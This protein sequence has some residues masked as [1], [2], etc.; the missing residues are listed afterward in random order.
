M[1]GIPASSTPAVCKKSLYIRSEHVWLEGPE[2]HLQYTIY[3]FSDNVHCWFRYSILMSAHIDS[4]SILLIAMS[5]LE[6]TSLLAPVWCPSAAAAVMV[7][8]KLHFNFDSNLTLEFETTFFCHSARMSCFSLCCCVFCAHQ[9]CSSLEHGGTSEGCVLR[10]W[11]TSY[12]TVCAGQQA[13]ISIIFRCRAKR[14]G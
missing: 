12:F 3:T 11:L 1:R 6:K 9:S 7:I 13:G 10:C 8:L 4:V 14:R 5:T 2:M